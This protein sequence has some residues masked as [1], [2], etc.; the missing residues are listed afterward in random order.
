MR[1]PLRKNGIGSGYAPGERPI[2]PAEIRVI[3]RESE[4]AARR[5]ITRAA[6][7]EKRA[8]RSRIDRNE[9]SD[10]NSRAQELRAAAEVLLA[11]V[12]ELSRQASAA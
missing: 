2:E 8:S 4:Q 11:E 9:R 10:L 6:H 7:L 1:S 5:L 12:C 3:A